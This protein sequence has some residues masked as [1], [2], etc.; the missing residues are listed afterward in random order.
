MTLTDGTTI[1]LFSITAGDIKVLSF[2]EPAFFE[3]HCPGNK[4]R[5]S[6]FELQA[7]FNRYFVISS[8]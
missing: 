2:Y 7:L 8:K 4:D 3:E 5:L 6:I 1:K